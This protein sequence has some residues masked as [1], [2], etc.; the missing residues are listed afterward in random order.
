[1][2][3]CYYFNTCYSN[4]KKYDNEQITASVKII[5]PFLTNGSLYCFQNSNKTLK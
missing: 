2:S 5:H 3:K 4:F 1:M